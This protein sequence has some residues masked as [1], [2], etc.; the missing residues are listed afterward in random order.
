MFWY[1]L[2]EYEMVLQCHLM[3]SIVFGL[4]VIRTAVGRPKG[5][6]KLTTKRPDQALLKVLDK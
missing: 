4:P 1:K 6:Q 5:F 3:N 2:I